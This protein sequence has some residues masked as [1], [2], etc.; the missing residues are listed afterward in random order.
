MLEHSD[1][2]T[3]QPL[4]A[5][6]AIN[7]QEDMQ[8]FTH[9]AGLYLAPSSANGGAAAA[10]NSYAATAAAAA[11]EA[12]SAA[13]SPVGASS[14]SQLVAHAQTN[15][16]ADALASAT[17]LVAFLAPPPARDPNALARVYAHE[18]MK[19]VRHTCSGTADFFHLSSP[20][21]CVPRQKSC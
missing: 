20:F 8:E 6:R 17:P 5:A 10:G 4:I 2:F 13:E 11:V 14:Q 7:P 19:E 16:A 1:K 18:V 3:D 21:L 12:A 15:K 9:A